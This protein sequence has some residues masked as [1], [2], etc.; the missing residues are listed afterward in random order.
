MYRHDQIPVSEKT[1]RKYDYHFI[2][3][4]G[5]SGCFPNVT[6]QLRKVHILE[7]R[8]KRSS[9]PIGLRYFYIDAQTMFPVFGKIYDR[10]NVLWKYG[11]GGLAHP[12]YHLPHNEGSGVPM[13]DSSAVIDIQNKHCTALQMVTL[14]NP[15][16]IKQKDFEPSALNTGAR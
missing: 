5:H 6:W 9:H 3:F 13:L 1:A 15:K 12:D 10:G 7:G 16:R 2:S 14:T 8:P 11:M 4:H